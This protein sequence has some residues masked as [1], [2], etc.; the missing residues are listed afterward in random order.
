MFLTGQHPPRY[1]TAAGL[2][3]ILCHIWR[4]GMCSRQL[5]QS[6]RRCIRGGGRGLRWW[7]LERC[8][9]HTGGAHSFQS[10]ETWSLNCHSLEPR[11][12]TP[13]TMRAPPLVQVP[14]PAG[15]HTS[16]SHAG[17]AADRPAFP[18]CQL[19]TLPFALSTDTTASRPCQLTSSLYTDTT[20]F[21]PCQLSPLPFAPV[22][23]HYCLSPL[24]T[25]PTTYRS[26]ITATRPTRRARCAHHRLPVHATHLRT[27]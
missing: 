24:S 25:D 16:S 12:P 23:R 5:G 13:R 2:S 11:L 4:G 15:Q 20:A 18:A 19:T 9:G 10:I 27:R 1:S 17:R 3:S 7:W 26:N 8:S 14:A 6:A 22:N 21:H